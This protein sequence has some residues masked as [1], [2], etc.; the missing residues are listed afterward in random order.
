VKS[1]AVADGRGFFAKPGPLIDLALTLPVFLVYHLGVVFLRL[2]NGVDLLTGP[3]MNLAE[4][5]RATYLFLTGGI[6]A[7]FALVFALL[8]RG[9]AFRLSKFIQ[10]AVEGVVFAVVLRLGASYV[11]GNLFAGNVRD[12]GGALGGI[13]QSCGAGFYE[14]LIFRVILFGVGANVLVRI[15]AHERIGALVGAPSR[16]SLRAGAIMAFWCLVVSAVFSGMHYVGSVGDSFQLASFTFRFVL[17][18][19][20]TLIYVTRGF[21]AAVWAHMLYDVWVIVLK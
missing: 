18:V 1:A 3:L 2:R 14:E 21:A 17:G 5:D 10:I 9:Q 13:V 20:L 11:V 4:G 15:F 12:E 19:L 16:L 6:G 7:A 8:G